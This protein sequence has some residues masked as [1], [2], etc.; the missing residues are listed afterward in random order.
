MT[1]EEL[2]YENERLRRELESM[3][4]D[5]AA[6][7]QKLQKYESEE[8]VEPVEKYWFTGKYT[9]EDLLWCVTN[10]NCYGCP[11]FEDCQSADAKIPVESRHIYP[12]GL[13]REQLKLHAKKE[14]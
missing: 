8:R 10:G 4:R 2:I 7:R 3:H 9:I 5:M 11:M 1:N 12:V 6:L 13:T 14:G